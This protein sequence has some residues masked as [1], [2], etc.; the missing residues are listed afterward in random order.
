MLLQARALHFNF[1]SIDV[2]RPLFTRP[3]S[4]KVFRDFPCIFNLQATNMPAPRI[5]S[6]PSYFVDA[7]RPVVA[8]SSIRLT[9]EIR[10]DNISFECINTRTF[11]TE[12]VRFCSNFFLT[13]SQLL[14]RNCAQFLV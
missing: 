1:R 5:A 13:N 2:R 7:P 4:R 14:I 11:F 10:V 6:V 12:T 3:F 9:D 8:T